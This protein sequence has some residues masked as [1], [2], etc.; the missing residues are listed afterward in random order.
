MQANYDAMKFKIYL[1]N[2]TVGNREQTKGKKK[3][4]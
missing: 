4:N 1:K 3:K 2:S